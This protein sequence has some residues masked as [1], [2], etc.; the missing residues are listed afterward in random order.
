MIGGHWGLVPYMGKL[1]LENKIEAYNFPQGVI[2]H[3]RKDIAAGKPGT[4]THV[5]LNTFIDPDQT[6]GRLNS[7]TTEPLIEKIELSGR[8]WLFYKAFPI[9]VAFIRGT[10]ADPAGNITMEREAMIGEVLAATH[11]AHNSGG[12]VICQVE[13]LSEEKAI[14]REVVVPG[15]LVDVIVVADTQHHQQTFATEFTPA[16]SGVHKNK[17]RSPPGSPASFVLERSSLV[18]HLWK[19]V[20]NG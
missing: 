2:I 5:G 10:T 14:A 17:Y 6:G 18:E 7:I 16:F 13:R 19:S 20:K 11:A 3:Q 4:I 15:H 9:D 8:E 12:K 1:A